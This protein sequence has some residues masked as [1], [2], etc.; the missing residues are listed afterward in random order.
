MH[1][2]IIFLQILNNGNK[3]MQ[4]QDVLA[5]KSLQTYPIKLIK[6]SLIFKSSGT[7]MRLTGQ[8]QIIIK[9]EVS[10]IFG[11]HAQVLLFG[12]RVNDN[13][14]GGDIDLLIE[15]DYPVEEMLKKNL[16]L[17][18]ALQVAMGGLQKI[19]IIT[20]IKDTMETPIHKA[21][22]NTGIRL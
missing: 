13:E 20:H 8:Q 4:W 12:S 9:D 17:N 6:L 14:R 15:L 10:K 3:L 19:D 1:N 21:A 22:L 11:A 7:K 5:D 18:A 2:A 16:S